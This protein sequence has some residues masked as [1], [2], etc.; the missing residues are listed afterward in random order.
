[1]KKTITFL[2]MAL[3]GLTKAQNVANFD[4]FTLP[5]DSYYYSVTSVDFQTANAVF[6]YE[7]ST[8]FG[9]YWQSGFAYTNKNNVDSGNYRHLYNCIAGKGYNNS[10]YYATGQANGK[11]KLKTSTDNTVNG[12]YVTNSTYAYKSMK[13]GDL[14][15]K[16]FGGTTG[17][18]PDWF[19]LTVKGFFGGAMKTDSVEFYLADYRFSNNTLDYI[20]NGWQWVNCSSLG[21]VDSIQFFMYS[22]DNSAW[23]MN[24]PAFFSI[25]NFTTSQS[26][27][28]NELSLIDNVK[29]FPNPAN[30]FI[31]LNLSSETSFTS[32]L[33]VYNAIGALVQ[34]ANFNVINGSNTYKIELSELNSGLYFIEISEPNKKQTFKFIKN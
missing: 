12:F 3:F 25:D 7:W 4:N 14:F 2:L 31:N 24:T 8:S 29:L 21:I 15:A 27:G 28:I 33:K 19:K 6:E 17:N 23:G 9:G 1:M 30:D 16:K 13:N 18:D 22:T 10:T 5:V 20:V 34:S 11:I 32:Q 26:V